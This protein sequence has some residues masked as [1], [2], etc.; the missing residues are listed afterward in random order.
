MHKIE[1][2]VRTLIAKGFFAMSILSFPLMYA[3]APA[4][5]TQSGTDRQR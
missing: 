2:S 4:A 5:G 3:C 1:R